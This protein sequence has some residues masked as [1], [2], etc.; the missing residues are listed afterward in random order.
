VRV[1]QAAQHWE[2]HFGFGRVWGKEPQGEDLVSPAVCSKPACSQGH[3]G[4]PEVRSPQVSPPE[5]GVLAQQLAWPGAPGP[6]AASDSWVS[7]PLASPPRASAAPLASPGGLVGAE[8]PG[9]LGLPHLLPA[10]QAWRWGCPLSARKGSPC[11]EPVSQVLPVQAC[12]PASA[13]SGSLL[14]RH[15]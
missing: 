5:D 15:H 12:C 1:R 11:L 2:H 8:R 6:Q 13:M 10:G 4:V 14:P 9:G 7:A 3:W